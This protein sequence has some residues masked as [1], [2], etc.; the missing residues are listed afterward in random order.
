[1]KQHLVTIFIILASILI[2][3][4]LFIGQKINRYQAKLSS[5]YFVEMLHLAQSPRDQLVAKRNLG[6]TPLYVINLPKSTKRLE[7]IRKQQAHFNLENL[8]IIE[9]VN[10]YKIIDKNQDTIQMN[11][12]HPVSFVNNDLQASLPEI[13]CTLSHLQSIKTCWDQGKN[14]GI[15]LE[16][17]V[18]FDLLPLWESTI[19][20]VIKQANQQVPDWQAIYLFHTCKEN[21]TELFFDFLEHDCWSN[22]AYLVNRAGCQQVLNK[23]YDWKTHRYVLDKDQ[24][25]PGRILADLYVPGLLKAYCYNKKL[26][27]PNNNFADMDST[28]HTDHTSLH[29]N[30]TY[31]ALKPYYQSILSQTTLPPTLHIIN[32][33]E[34]RTETKSSWERFRQA[35]P[36]WTIQIWPR[37]AVSTQLFDIAYQYG[38]IVVDGNYSWSGLPPPTDSL[39]T[40]QTNPDNELQFNWISTVASHPYIKLILENNNIDMC[41]DV[42]DQIK[43][44]LDDRDITLTKKSF[45]TTNKTVKIIGPNKAY[46]Q[47]LFRQLHYYE[48]QDG[49]ADP[50]DVLV[51]DVI[52]ESKGQSQATRYKQKVLYSGEAWDLSKY[53]YDVLIDTKKVRKLRNNNKPFIYL[54]FCV[55]SFAER[56]QA[57]MSTLLNNRASPSSLSSQAQSSPSLRPKTK[58]CAFL[59]S[60]DVDFRNKLFDTICQYKPVDALGKCRGDPSK[61][62][63]RAHSNYNDLAVEK[64]ADY[65]FVICCENKLVPGYITEKIISAYLAGAIPIYLGAP[66]IQDYFNIDSMIRV[67]Q[68]DGTADWLDKLKMIDQNQA[69]Y[70]RMVRAK[71]VKNEKIFQANYILSELEECLRK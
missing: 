24:V 56:S 46:F 60:H 50:V 28:I 62:Q 54:P 59:Y 12:G 65:K 34:L 10:G 6:D 38:G 30:S 18:S 45:V 69:E 42:Y 11:S 15:I 44:Y 61:A 27:I 13:G 8:Q 23:A 20:E 57:N 67:D 1:M 29:V 26:I 14:Y 63:E 64:Y 49:D 51:I 52:S 68:N 40:L 47:P 16:D 58:F 33:G 41:Q 21:S 22:A 5:N 7:N 71:P 32:T 53:K 19:D 35:Y 37:S 4:L 55:L 3:T 2:I 17:D 25:A 48:C 43:P 39:L 70:E 31:Q 36:N 66:D 9:A